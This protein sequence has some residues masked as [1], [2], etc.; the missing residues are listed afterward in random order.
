MIDLGWR[1][2]ACSLISTASFVLP[3]CKYTIPSR[4][5]TAGEA[6]GAFAAF[7]RTSAARSSCFRAIKRR[8]NRARE[9]RSMDQD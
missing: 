9:P 6:S 2:I 7:F 3:S 5:K 1:L 8:A 4:A